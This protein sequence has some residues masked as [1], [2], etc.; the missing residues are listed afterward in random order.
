MPKCGFRFVVS[1]ALVSAMHAIS[2]GAHAADP[3][4]PAFKRDMLASGLFYRYG[5]IGGLSASVMF[6]TGAINT[7]PHVVAMPF[8]AASPIGVPFAFSQ[9]RTIT[10]RYCAARY[11]GQS[12][13]SAQAAADEVAM[14]EYFS[15][16]AGH[17]DGKR[18]A[19][20]GSKFR[21]AVD[22]SIA[23]RRHYVEPN[24][25]DPDVESARQDSDRARRAYKDVVD[26]FMRAPSRD[27]STTD[28]ARAA[29]AANDA[30]SPVRK[31]EVVEY[32]Y[33]GKL[34][35]GPLQEDLEKSLL[36]YTPKSVGDAAERLENEE[37]VRAL[38]QSIEVKT[39]WEMGRAGAYCLLNALI[40]RF[41][42][43]VPL[44]FKTG[45]RLGADKNGAATDAFLLAEVQTK[46]SFGLAFA[47]VWWFTVLTGPVIAAAPRAQSSDLVRVPMW[48]VGVGGSLDIAGTLLK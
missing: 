29:I 37:A 2:P 6:G 4:A 12:G 18:Y 24:D 31:S 27:K 1:I 3:S 26:E 16:N 20:A 21:A 9:K 38:Y 28:L 34:I 15:T 40:P 47:P 36:R 5:L 32:L 23:R 22:E 14:A 17:L 42:V 19:I 43:G 33:G 7:Q 35:P 8:I 39:G 13:A 44:G 48:T 25:L 30:L 10:N 45:V 11:V 46:V 41:Y